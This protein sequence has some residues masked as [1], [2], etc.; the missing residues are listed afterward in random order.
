MVRPERSTTS[1]DMSTWQFPAVFGR[2]SGKCDG[3]GG[4]LAIATP[5]EARGRWSFLVGE[6]THR[7]PQLRGHLREF[8]DGA[9]GLAQ[10]L[11]GV[12]RRGGDAGDVLGDLGR[13]ARG[14]AHRA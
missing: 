6:A 11:R 5:A 8:V 13:A 12:P 14:L 1:S 4:D 7:A 2:V 3:R 10:G 9:A